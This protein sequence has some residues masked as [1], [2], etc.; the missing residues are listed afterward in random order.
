MGPEKCRVAGRIFAEQYYL[1]LTFMDKLGMNVSCRV[2]SCSKF[3]VQITQFNGPSPQRIWV[4]GSL[5]NGTRIFEVWQ[6]F[7]PEEVD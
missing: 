6:N 4:L 2:C 5:E 7:A 1:S 3:F